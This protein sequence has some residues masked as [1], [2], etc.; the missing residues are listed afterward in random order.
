MPVSTRFSE[1]ELSLL[2]QASDLLGLKVAT[3]IRDSSVQKAVALINAD[4]QREKLRV[5]ARKLVDH[6]KNPRFSRTRVHDDGAEETDVIT[7]YEYFHP[8]KGVQS[9]QELYDHFLLREGWDVGPWSPI[10]FS[11]IDLV[12]IKTAFETAGTVFTDI[13]NECWQESFFVN[14]RYEP[15]IKPSDL[16]D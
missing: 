16:E 2:N 6:L 4:G 1:K 12:E 3:F 13:L 8:D 10:T 7:A 14:E 15:K 9:E 11:L 5:A